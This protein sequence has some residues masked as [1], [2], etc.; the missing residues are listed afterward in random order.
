MTLPQNNSAQKSAL[1]EQQK[2][3]VAKETVVV[4]ATKIKILSPANQET[5]RNSLGDILVTLNT[6]HPL[7]E[8][9]F[10]VLIVNGQKLEKQKSLVWQLSNIDRGAHKVRAELFDN[11]KLI[12]RSQVVTLF[13]QRPIKAMPKQQ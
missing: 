4:K 3:P 1:F 8:K 10:I 6:D 9:Q 11:K 13:L 12:A 2:Q 7:G 5:I